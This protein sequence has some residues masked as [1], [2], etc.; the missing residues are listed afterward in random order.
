VLQASDRQGRHDQARNV[1]REPRT[2]ARSLPPEALERRARSQLSVAVHE[3]A[4]RTR[5]HRHL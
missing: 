4:A 3:G 1:W 5:T 2:G